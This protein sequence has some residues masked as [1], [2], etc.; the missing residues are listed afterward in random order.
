MSLVEFLLARISEDEAAAREAIDPARP[1]ERWSWE[2]PDDAGDPDTPRWLRTVEEFPTSSGVGPLPSFPLG[3]E[4][5]AEPARG[6]AH[7]ARHDPARV[8]A[9]CEAKRSIVELHL[10]TESFRWCITCTDIDVAPPN[11]VEAYPCRSLRALA[12]PYAGHEDY[13]EAW[14]V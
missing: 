14:R 5:R 8:L 13:D 3:S 6:M 11:N 1:G 9:E 2:V 12:L 4:F 7:I 10:P